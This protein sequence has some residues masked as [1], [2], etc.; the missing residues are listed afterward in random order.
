MR[1]KPLKRRIGFL[2]GKGKKAA[3]SELRTMHFF[4][5]TLLQQSKYNLENAL[6]VVIST[7]PRTR[8]TQSDSI[9]KRRPSEQYHLAGQGQKH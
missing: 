4:S 3:V 1:L 6:G 7:C 8:N 9:N 5:L 2:S